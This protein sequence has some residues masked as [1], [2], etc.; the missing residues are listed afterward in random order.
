MSPAIIRVTPKSPSAL[1][2]AST[3]ITRLS[4]SGSV[5]TT[6]G[7]RVTFATGMAVV[8]AAQ[9]VIKDLMR[10]AARLYDRLILAVAAGLL[11]GD[12]AHVRMVHG[13]KISEIAAGMLI[14]ADGAHSRVRELAA[15]ELPGVM[16]SLSHEVMPAAP[17][18]RATVESGG[19]IAAIAALMKMKAM[20]A[21]R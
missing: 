16:V 17:D 11:E 14:A 8:Q 4:A 2:K 9:T 19:D 21:G 13:D 10:R 12:I 3:A 15:E 1:A 20:P 5:N 18:I 6:G 7:S